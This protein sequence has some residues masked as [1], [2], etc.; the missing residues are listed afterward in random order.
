M[1]I[2][3]LIQR[4][5]RLNLQQSGK[6]GKFSPGPDGRSANSSF[7]ALRRRIRFVTLI[8]HRLRREAMPMVFVHG[9]ATRQAREYQSFVEQRDALFKRLVIGEADA[10]FDPDWGSNAVRF[11]QG[12]WVP[13]PG[14]N[15][16]LETGTPVVS[17]GISVASAVASRNIE[18]G[19]DL[20]LAAL[21]AQ[22]AKSQQP[23]TD[24]D[25]AVFE[26]AVRYLEAG[27]DR[28]AFGSIETDEQF[29]H[30]LRDELNPLLPATSIEPM[31]FFSDVF[32]VIGD[33]VKRVTDPI[34][35][36]ASD[37]VLR[38]VREPLSNQVALFLGDI[39]VYLRYR[40]TD[41]VHG[42]Y[43]RIF[44]PIIDD[45]A[46]AVAAHRAGQKLVVVGHSLGA[47][48]LYDLLTNARAL[49]AVRDAA[50]KELAIDALVTVGAQPGLFA[51]MGLFGNSEPGQL[52][53]PGC[54]A[55]WM[56]VFDYTDVLSFQCEPFFTGVK[57]FAFDNV[58]G[59]LEAHSAYFQRP[60][61]YKQ[62][63]LRLGSP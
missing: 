24:K 22:R 44:Q 25:I 10:I 55:E 52:P 54:A 45:L 31:A 8:R 57:D 19:I 62:L 1:P 12:G 15:E 34:R 9:V 36:A 13:E 46:R 51:D 63:R 41:G 56:N 3:G 5:T 21:L 11:F 20:A 43:N 30:S 4:E 7:M 27:G 17:T 28:G 38:L 16:A 60:S 50:G 39:F 29:A 23:I 18:Q 40:E 32:S 42:S 53:R 47:V 35:N 59:A 48:I 6:P 61:F 58:S 49:Q 14:A 26:A 37:G 33:A 2:D